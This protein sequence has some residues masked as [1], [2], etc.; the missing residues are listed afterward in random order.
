M[1]FL[2]RESL[3]CRVCSTRKRDVPVRCEPDGFDVQCSTVPIALEILPTRLR[4]LTPC[5]DAALTDMLENTICF[6]RMTN[7]SL[8]CLEFHMHLNVGNQRLSDQ[9]L[10]NERRSD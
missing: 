4:R 8:R 6:Q 2:K 7:T 3:A 10:T 5:Y 1:C 9:R